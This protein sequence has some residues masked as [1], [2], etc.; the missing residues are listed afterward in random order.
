MLY[1]SLVSDEIVSY[2]GVIPIETALSPFVIATAYIWTGSAIAP[3]FKREVSLVLAV[4][5]VAA[6][7]SLFV[8]LRGAKLQFS[9]AGALAGVAVGLYLAWRIPARLSP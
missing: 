4:L 6:F 9:G 1:S 3:K 8:F 5:Y 2:R 7:V